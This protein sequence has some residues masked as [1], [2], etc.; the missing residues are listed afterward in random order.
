M[1]KV[2]ITT[3]AEYKNWSNVEEM[4]AEFDCS[5]NQNNSQVIEQ[6]KSGK[7]VVLDDSDYN[8]NNAITKIK[9]KTL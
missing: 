5:E 3:T 7:E 2:T 1:I 6:I 8:S 9:A 4:L